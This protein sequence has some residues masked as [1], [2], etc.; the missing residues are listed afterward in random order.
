MKLDLQTDLRSFA[1]RLDAMQAEIPKAAAR[2]LNRTAT[3]VRAQAVRE[4]R[5][6]VPLSAR[7]FKARVSIE[8]ASRTTLTARVLARRDYDPALSRFTPRWRQRQAIGASVKVGMAGRQSIAGAFTAL[9]RWGGVGVFRREGRA[10][11]P[12]R[13]L[14]ASDIGAPT[15]QK[16]FLQA[17]TDGAMQR[18]A[19]DRFRAVLAQELRFR[20]GGA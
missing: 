11:Y 2:A 15:L 12:I 17:T 16:A 6:Q 3:T 4:I 18:L 19:R 20:Q 1:L 8:R 10:R 9:T 13:F 14:R 5:K 7:A